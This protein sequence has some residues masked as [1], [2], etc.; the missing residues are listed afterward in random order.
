M[1]FHATSG[2]KFGCDYLLHP[3]DEATEGKNHSKYCAYFDPKDPSGKE[4]RKYSGT[5]IVGMCRAANGVRKKVLIAACDPVFDE[6]KKIVSLDENQ[7][8]ALRWVRNPF[9]Q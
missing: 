9:E 1:K 3:V 2:L 6:D 7:C 4:T 5:D 8:C